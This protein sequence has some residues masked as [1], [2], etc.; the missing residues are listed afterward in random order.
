[1]VSK[2]SFA[3][4][5]WKVVA[6]WQLSS[7]WEAIFLLATQLWQHV[8]QPYPLA[9]PFVTISHLCNHNDNIDTPASFKFTNHLTVIKSCVTKD[10]FF[11]R[12][13]LAVITLLFTYF[14]YLFSNF[15]YR[16]IIP[17]AIILDFE[18][19][20]ILHGR[21]SKLGAIETCATMAKKRL[22]DNNGGRFN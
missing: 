14:I 13:L 6:E 19:L 1:M 17:R 16:R 20:L 18:V 12:C 10:T 22:G 9:F 5:G 21:I 3:Q 7:K 4:R 2:F 11:T 8:P 15:I